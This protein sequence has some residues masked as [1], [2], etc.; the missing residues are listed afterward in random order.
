MIAWLGP[1]PDFPP[2]SA[3]LTEPNGL[4]A[5]GG[6]LSPEWLLAAYGRGIFPWFNQ[7]EPILWWSPDPRLV[8]F[9]QDLH[10]SRSLR[11]ELQ[12][13]RFEVRTDSA[14][15]QV[16]RACA[17]PRACSAATWITPQMQQAYLR[18]H[19][20]GHAHSVECW[21]D[22]K[23]VGG[24]YGMA[25][26]QIFFGESMFS[27]VRDASKVALAH[28]SRLLAARGYVMIDCQMTTPHLLSMGAREIP[29]QRFCRILAMHGAQTPQPQHWPTSAAA[30]FDWH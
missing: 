1:E 6:A 17:A 20:L 21:Q 3:A 23:L 16:V 15:A 12:R 14:F 7:G 22:E 8:L 25:L 5:A 30:G 26:G 4:L 24:L 18:M 28:L 27:T 9:P 19:E 10:I 11:R 29:R 13:G 2:L